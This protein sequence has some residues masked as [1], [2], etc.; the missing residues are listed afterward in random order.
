MFVV[1]VLIVVEVVVDG[2]AVDI[3]CRMEFR[4]TC[5]S[6]SFDYHMYRL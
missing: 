2:V 5:S 4:I 6:C 3:L 1:E